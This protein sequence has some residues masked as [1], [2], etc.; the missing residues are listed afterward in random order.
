MKTWLITG[1]SSGIGRGIAEA[2]LKAGEQVVVTARRL[3]TIKDIVADFP[4]TALAVELDV[5]NSETI[6][7]AVAQAIE[8]FST[9]DVLVNNAGYAYR[10]AIEEGEADEIERIFETNFFGPL[11]LINEVLPHMRLQKS[12]LIMNISSP[13][14]I[15]A[16]PGSGY[17]AA[18]KSALESITEA[19]NDELSHIGIES[20]V[21]QP[22]QFD[23]Q[24]Y[25]SSLSDSKTIITDYDETAAKNRKANLKQDTF[26]LGDPKKAGEL[27]VK[28]ANQ[29]ERPFRLIIGSDSIQ[30]IESYYQ[31]RLEELEKWREYASFTDKK[32]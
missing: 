2:A 28:I 4:T 14:A 16:A 9:I 29:A 5:T 31:Q 15:K 12:G 24:F 21:L 22:G 13:S 8:S 26:Y 10:G 23:T 1:C 25:S 6:K 19:L 32:E 20:M 11:A 18:T 30:W 3:E 17:Y 7:K 27:I